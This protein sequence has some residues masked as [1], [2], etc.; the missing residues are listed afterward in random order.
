[1]NEAKPQARF[2]ALLFD[3]AII[4]AVSLIIMFRPILAMIDV[5]VK[6]T[7]GNIISLFVSALLSGGVVMIFMFIYFLVLPVHWKGQT[8]G[9]RFFRVRVI[10]TDGTDVTFQ[11]LFLREVIG[12]LLIVFMS[13]GFS[14]LADIVM[15]LASETHQTFHDTLAFTKVI[16]VE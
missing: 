12:R 7:N 15:I 10:K 2:F 9:K 1:M 4:Y 13:F 6:H 16:N 5:F 8:I 14:I 3:L 11:T